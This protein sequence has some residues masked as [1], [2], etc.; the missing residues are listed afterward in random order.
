MLEEGLEC[1]LEL[2]EVFDFEEGCVFV[3]LL[4]CE[5]DEAG[6]LLEWD[7]DVS[8]PGECGDGGGDEECGEPDGGDGLC[9]D[10]D[11]EDDGREAGGEAAFLRGGD[12]GAEG[13]DFQ[14]L[15][16]VWVR[17][18]EWRDAGGVAESKRDGRRR[19]CG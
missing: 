14:G 5:G 7:F 6:E 10:R 19:V 2:F 4:L 15:H 3:V 17:V 16:G 18:S 12:Q 11:A 13:G 8:V 9:G 1:V